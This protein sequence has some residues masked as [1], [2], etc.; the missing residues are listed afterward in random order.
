MPTAPPS[1]EHDRDALVRYLLSFRWSMR[2]EEAEHA[3]VR[4]GVRLWQRILDFVPEAPAGARAL[5]IGSPP[6][7]VTLLL[8]RFRGHALSLSAFPVGGEHE[9][10]RELESPEYG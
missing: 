10:T 2:D 3:V 1:T 4:G 6:F 5:E 8:K 7:H 9:L